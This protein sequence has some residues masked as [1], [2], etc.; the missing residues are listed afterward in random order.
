[1]TPNPPARV[2]LTPLTLVAFHIL[3]ALASGER[4]GYAIMRATDLDA[5]TVYRV[6]KRLRATGL[7]VASDERT[8]LANDDER[9]RYYCLTPQGRAVAQAETRRLARL[10]A[11]ARAALRSDGAAPIL[12]TPRSAYGRENS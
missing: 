4:H 10:V 6:I 8:M 9:R 12:D 5:G 11:Y 3:L 2:S 7:V 1:M